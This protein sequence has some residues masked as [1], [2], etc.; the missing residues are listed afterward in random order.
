MQNPAADIAAQLAGGLAVAAKLAREYGTP[1]DMKLADDWEAK[2]VAALQY[3]E[4]MI[5]A[6]SLEG[7]T[8]T[9]SSTVANCVGS[10][11]TETDPDDGSPTEGVRSS[12]PRVIVYRAHVMFTVL[13]CRSSCVVLL[14]YSR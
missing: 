2:A 11:C 1:E 10:T 12:N 9:K 13:L 5:A 3:A 4:R 8:C 6:F 7:S 14:A